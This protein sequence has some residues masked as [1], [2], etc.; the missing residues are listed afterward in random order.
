M[1]FAY[2]VPAGSPRRATTGPT[3]PGHRA[4][5][6]RRLG[7]R[8]RRDARPQPLLPI[9]ARRARAAQGFADRIEVGAHDESTIERQIAAV[10][11]GA[12]DLAVLADLFDTP[13]PRATPASAGRALARAGAERSGGDH[14]LGLPQR[15]A[16]A[17]STTVRRAAGG[18]LRDRPRQVVE[19][20]GGP[21]VGELDLPGRAERLPRLRAVLPVHRVARAGRPL[22]RSRHGAGAPARGGVGASRRARRS[23]G[24]R[25]SGRRSAATT[26]G[27]STSSAS[28]RRVRVQAFDNDDVYDPRTR[29]QTG[30]AGWG[31]DYLAAST[32]ITT[33]VR[34][35]GRERPQPL[36]DLR[37]R[38]W[39]A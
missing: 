13:G 1:H 6:R 4:V 38:R 32:F 33:D 30:F 5:P 29:A 3:P 37:P 12:A 24:C 27:C 35:A 28:A 17:R 31:A 36:A 2:V 18:Q 10:Q 11:R 8:S 34:R 26:R 22:D 19:L 25:T 39:S 16:S 20:A 9:R 21:E 14:G 23:S 7:R 15:A